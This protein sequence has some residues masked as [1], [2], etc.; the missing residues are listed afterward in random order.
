MA[1]YLL[2]KLNLWLKNLLQR[3][4][5][6]QVASWVNIILPNILERDNINSSQTLSENQLGDNTSQCLS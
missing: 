6:A 4:L 2:Q 3:K 1:L 5:Q